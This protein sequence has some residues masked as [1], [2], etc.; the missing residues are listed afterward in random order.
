ML[1]RFH[2]LLIAA[3]AAAVLAALPL[4]AAATPA[5]PKPV[6]LSEWARPGRVL[7]LRHANAPGSGDPPGFRLASCATQR[8]LD[9]A[10]RAQARAAGA[11]LRAALV[12]GRVTSRPALFASQW[13]RANETANLLGLGPHKTLPPLNE[14]APGDPKAASQI[15][16]LRKAVAALP[17]RGPPAVLVTHMGVIAGLA[18]PGAPAAAYAG[19]AIFELNGGG[20]PRYVGPVAPIAPVA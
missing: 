9:A 13:C 10:G 4:A 5:A 20:A 8:N 3:A 18:P 16:A 2:A 14:L 7:L 12:A 15:A 17:P 6:P 11:A 1:R 19:G